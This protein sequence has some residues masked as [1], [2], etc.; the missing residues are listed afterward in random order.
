MVEE[1]EYWRGEFSENIETELETGLDI[2]LGIIMK[3]ICATN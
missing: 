2:V 1:K 3:Y